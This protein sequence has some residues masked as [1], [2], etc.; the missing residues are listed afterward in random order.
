MQR[1]LVEHL[2]DQLVFSLKSHIPRDRTLNIL[3]TG[4]GSH[5]SFLIETLG[6]KLQEAHVVCNVTVPS[7]VEVEF[8]EA[9]IMAFLGLFTLLGRSNISS[10]GTGAKFDSVS[11]SIH[12]PAQRNLS[13]IFRLG[14]E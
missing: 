9:I 5:N 11:G 10:A 1:T 2:C 13:K 8:K 3:A 7:Q 6:H 4:G 14:K 12:L